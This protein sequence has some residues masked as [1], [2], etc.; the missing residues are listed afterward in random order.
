VNAQA[1]EGADPGDRPLR[2]TAA[3]ARPGAL[4]RLILGMNALG[5]FWV[6]LLVLLITSDA[7]GRTF[8]NYPIAGT[9]EMVQIS[10]VGI[11]FLQLADAIRT[12]RLTRSDS[13]LAVAYSRWPRL[14]AALDGLFCALGAIFMGIGLWGSI[15][16]LKEAIERRSYLGNEGIFTAPVWPVKTIIV[17]GL[18][19]CLL[20][21]L[22]LAV[23]AFRR[24]RP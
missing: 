17:V 3:G 16:L 22:R 12:G 13:F 4:D 21:F 20:Q 5:S 24:M 9:H 14:A 1:P 8:L 7:L 15:P 10:V 19:V 11:V 18:G 2:Q 23:A 6:L